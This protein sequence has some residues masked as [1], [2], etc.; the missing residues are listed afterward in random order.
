VTYEQDGPVVRV[1]G[2]VCGYVAAASDHGVRG[3]ELDELIVRRRIFKRL[4]RLL[5]VPPESRVAIRR[6][7]LRL[8]AE[9]PGVITSDSVEELSG[10]LKP[11]FRPKFETVQVVELIRTIRKIARVRVSQRT[12]GARIELPVALRL[13][14]AVLNLLRRYEASPTIAR[15]RTEARGDGWLDLSITPAP[16]VEERNGLEAVRLLAQC[17]SDDGRCGEL[18]IDPGVCATLRIP[19]AHA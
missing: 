11:M 9:N 16:E 13:T 14:G 18:R 8:L 17:R 3:A 15:V 12:E 4:A 19:I 7:T 10:V 5:K 6:Q 1:V 2:Q